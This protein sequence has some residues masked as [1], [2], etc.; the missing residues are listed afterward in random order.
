MTVRTLACV[1]KLIVI[2]CLLFCSVSGVL[3][4]VP[5]LYMSL[6]EDLSEVVRLLPVAAGKILQAGTAIYG[7]SS[8]A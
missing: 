3:Q 6:V 4:K 1:S 7:M 5:G 2:D 8:C